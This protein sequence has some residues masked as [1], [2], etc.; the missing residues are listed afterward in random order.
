MK[1][2]DDISFRNIIVAKFQGQCFEKGQQLKKYHMIF[3]FNFSLNIL[4]IIPS[5]ISLF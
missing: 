1:V 5:Y 3:F 4:F 2:Q